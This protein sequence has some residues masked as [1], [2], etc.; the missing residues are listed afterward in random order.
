MKHEECRRDF[1]LRTLALGALGSFAASPSVRAEVSGSA[2]ESIHSLRGELRVNGRIATAATLI[3][4]QD[5]LQTGADSQVIFRVG[6]DAFILRA[7]SELHFSGDDLLVSGLR[8]VS[9]ALLSVFG[10]GPHDIVTPTATIGIRGTGVYVEAQA[11]RA[12]VCDCYGR[13][14]IAAATNPA[15]SETVVST[16]HNARYVT[17]DGKLHT[18]PFL[19]HGDD[20]LMLIESLVGRTPP[21]S[22]PG[23]GSPKR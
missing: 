14:V 10:K 9:G 16:H 22:L 4:G 11:D 17:A 5:V 21:F 23:D 18:A 8:L 15:A 13:T 1:L 3:G 19:H 6:K 2:S 7:K 20:E 12:Y